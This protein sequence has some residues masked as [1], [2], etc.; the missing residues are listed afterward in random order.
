MDLFNSFYVIISLLH[1]AINLIR[2][3]GFWREKTPTVAFS[4][5]RTHVFSML[6]NIS[7][8]QYGLSKELNMY[9][10]MWK[11]LKK[12]RDSGL[13]FQVVAE[14]LVLKF[15]LNKTNMNQ[16]L[17]PLKGKIARN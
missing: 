11:S 6:I 5:L 8:K 10:I 3:D 7:N 4:F 9:E 16:A 2:K 15:N 14:C 13:M 12:T 1:P 17:H